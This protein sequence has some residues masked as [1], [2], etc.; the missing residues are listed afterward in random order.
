MYKRTM[1]AFFL[2]KFVL[3]CF[4]DSHKRKKIAFHLKDLADNNDSQGDTS[5]YKWYR[6]DS[7]NLI[8]KQDHPYMK[9]L[10]EIDL[11]QIPF[12]VNNFNQLNCKLNYNTEYK[13]CLLYTS[14]SPR[15]KRQSRMPSSA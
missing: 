7:K 2:H 11:S 10:K 13:D 9:R 1:N 5:N 15:D 3:F 6:V 4:V 8:N 12:K 14:P